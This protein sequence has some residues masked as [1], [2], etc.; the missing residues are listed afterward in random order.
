MR[1]RARWD[2]VIRQVSTENVEE[3]M[4][5]LDGRDRE[6]LLAQIGRYP[7]SDEGWAKLHLIG[8]DIFGRATVEEWREAERAYFARIRLGVEAIRNV[9]CEK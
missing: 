6:E 1:V 9:T 4:V 5:V 7:D 8:A 2:A 3:L